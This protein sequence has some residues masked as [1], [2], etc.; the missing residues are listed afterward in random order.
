M[1]FNSS[2]L[3][4]GGRRDDRRRR[5][6]AEDRGANLDS[7]GES[8]SGGSRPVAHKSENYGDAAFLQTQLRLSDLVPRGIVLLVLMPLVGAALIAGLTTLYVVAPGLFHTPDHQP[9]MTV[10]GGPGSL[11]NWLSSLLLLLATFYAVLNYTIR[12]HKTDDYHGRY[13]AWLWAAACWFLMATDT[14][15]SL[16]QG[17]RDVLIAMTGARITGDGSIWWLCP[18]AVLLGLVS[19]RLLIDMR[20]CK[21]ASAAFFLRSLPT[22]RHSRYSSA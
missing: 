22:S 7:P 6:L 4:R 11:G 9:A 17:V 3:G 20:P 19:S 18:A 10:L 1:A 2:P 12:R 13:R 15:A 8:T 14:A 5:L 16:H 21:T